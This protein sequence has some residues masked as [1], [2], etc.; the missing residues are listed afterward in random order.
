LLLELSNKTSQIGSL[1]VEEE[2]NKLRKE[3]RILDNKNSINM[4]MFVESDVYELNI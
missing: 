3:Y 4:E 1:K 2:G